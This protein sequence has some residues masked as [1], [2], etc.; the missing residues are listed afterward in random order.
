MTILDRDLLAPGGMIAVDNTLLQGEPYL[1]GE[2]SANG[3]AIA[4]FNAAIAGDP[5]IEQVLL[6]VRDGLTLIRRVG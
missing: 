3:R 1:P 6:A 4:H 5:R 2:P